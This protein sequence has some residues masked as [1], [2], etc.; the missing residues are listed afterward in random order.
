[1]QSLL[2]VVVIFSIDDPFF[3]IQQKRWKWITA[4]W[5]ID[6]FQLHSS[7]SSIILYK[8]EIFVTIESTIDMHILT[9]YSLRPKWLK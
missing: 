8:W 4:F 9:V 6:D 1:M 2:I 5:N 7:P 3:I